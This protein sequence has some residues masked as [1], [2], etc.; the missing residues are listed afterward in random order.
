MP[1]IICTIIAF[2]YCNN[3]EK[4]VGSLIPPTIKVTAFAAAIALSSFLQRIIYATAKPIKAYVPDIVPTIIILS[5][6]ILA[7]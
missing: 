5:A 6:P 2:L 4:T 3:T 7:I 1:A